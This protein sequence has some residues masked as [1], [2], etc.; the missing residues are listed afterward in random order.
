M[1]LFL[2]RGTMLRILQRG[3]T[4][5]MQRGHNLSMVRH[6]LPHLGRKVFRQLRAR[7]PPILQGVQTQRHHTLEDLFS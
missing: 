5:S 3:D 6:L 2:L 4:L 1:I 7:Q